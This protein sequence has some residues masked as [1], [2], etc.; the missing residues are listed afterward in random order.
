MHDNSF[1]AP[2]PSQPYPIRNQRRVAFLKPLINNPH[3][4]VGEFTYFDDP[5]GP[6]KFEARNV[7]YHFDFIGDRLVIGKFCAIA[8]G[9][10]FI[11]NGANHDLRGISTY[12]FPV[13]GGD[14]AENFDLD[15]FR[16]QS[17]GDLTVGDDV[18]LGRNATVM[19]GVTIGSGAIIAAGAIVSRDVPAYGVV[20]GNPAELVKMRFRDDDIDR[21]IAL[22]WW[23]WPI[24]MITKYRPL[25][26]AG[27]INALEEAA[28][29]FHRYS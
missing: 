22:S 15:S 17:R 12:P 23:D 3:I 6:E 14:W 8:T 26:Q 13:M 18:W 27:D 21:L 11:M 16:A 10:T 25:I 9:V 4:R 19:P 20:A 24:A 5:E 29:T 2:D 7:L 28:K 1:T